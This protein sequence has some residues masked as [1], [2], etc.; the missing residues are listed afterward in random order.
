[1]SGAS[2]V[3]YALSNASGDQLNQMIDFLRRSLIPGYLYK[4]I[5]RERSGDLR[6]FS[7]NSSSQ[8]WLYVIV[9][10]KVDGREFWRNV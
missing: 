5:E 10:V 7:Q 2:T 4:Y 8:L 9:I 1:M 3:L 6:H